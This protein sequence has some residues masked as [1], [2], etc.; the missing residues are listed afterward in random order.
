M[1]HQLNEHVQAAIER[2][3]IFDLSPE[4]FSDALP[5]EIR[6]LADIE[7]TDRET[8]LQIQFHTSLRF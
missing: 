4:H 5:G 7:F 6:I 3:E 1:S 8:E 2:L